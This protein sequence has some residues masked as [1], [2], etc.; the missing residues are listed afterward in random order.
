M[1]QYLLKKGIAFIKLSNP[2]VN[3]L[4]KNVRV[5]IMRGLDAAKADK[6]DCVVLHGD[7]KAFS[8]GAD[9]AEFATGGHLDTSL[10]SVLDRLDAFDLPVISYITGVALGG[11]LETALAT[12]WRVASPKALVGLPEVH[13]G[14]LPG[15]GGTQRLPRLCAI[16]KAVEIMTSG[17][18]VSAQEALESGIVDRLAARH[19][20]SPEELEAE[21]LAFTRAD[22]LLDCD[23]ALRR[24]SL[25]PVLGG[26]AEVDAAMELV[27]K[28]SRG[29]LA[30]GNIVRAVG[31]AVECGPGAEGFARGL[32]REGELFTELAKGPQARALQYFFF[33]ERKVNTAPKVPDA[34]TVTNVGII[35]GGT[36]GAGIAMSFLNAKIPVT[37]VE[38]DAQAAEAARNRIEQTYKASSAYRQGRMSAEKLDVLLGGLTVCADMS[39]LAESD[40]V[41]EAA[42]ENSAVKKE[43]FARLDKICKPDAVLATNTSC[44]DIDEI[45]GATAPARRPNVVGTRKPAV[46]LY[47]CL[48]SC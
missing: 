40:L 9:I 48:S 14:I 30:P 35:G 25:R 15:A 27:R 23:L 19:D 11:G 1:A 31:A 7:G 45:A 37:L 16:P 18:M 26:Q 8:A 46:C 44:L 20:P 22:G 5:G 24:V 41:V 43:I 47:L 39:A 28:S 38:T 17:R 12:H 42:F 21:M 34:P 4:S 29:M 2:P 33:S 13:L 32:R 3:S 36:M 10:G 6:A